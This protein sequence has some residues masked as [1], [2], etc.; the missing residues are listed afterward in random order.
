VGGFTVMAAVVAPVLQLYPVPPLAVNV[1]FSPTQILADAGDIDGVGK[2]FTVT[3]A[4][5][6]AVHPAALVTVT[7]YVVVVAGFI[8]IADVVAPVLQLYPVPPLAMSVVLS[9]SQ[10]LAEA[11]AIEGVGKAFTVTVAPVL[12]VHPAALVTVTV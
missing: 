5:V 8:V 3:V 11:G 2:A 1:V 6:L 7:V 4:L 12:A 9:P 10:I